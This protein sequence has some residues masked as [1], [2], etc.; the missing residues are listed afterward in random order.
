MA[1]FSCF[2]FPFP[3][4]S[5]P[6]F[7]LSLDLDSSSFCSFTDVSLACAAR[8]RN[9]VPGANE[10]VS[11]GVAREGSESVLGMEVVLYGVD[12]VRSEGSVVLEESV[13]L[14]S[15]DVFVAVEFKLKRVLSRDVFVAVKFKLRRVLSR[16]AFVVVKFKLRRALSR[17]AFVVV[18][19]GLTAQGTGNV[20]LRLSGGDTSVV[21]VDVVELV[22]VS[23]TS[24]AT[25][26]LLRL[27]FQRVTK[28]SIEKRYPPAAD[29]RS[30]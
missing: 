27:L 6:C 2:A 3:F 29:W 10:S 22:V 21:F 17:D 8:R 23:V 20:P 9:G 11:E 7:D 16:D 12:K 28:G 19:A 18:F 1:A 26:E 30:R 15:R 5:F 25:F 24:L 13:V 14:L 4:L